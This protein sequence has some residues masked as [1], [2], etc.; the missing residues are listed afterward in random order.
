[1][2]FQ[3]SLVPP[4]EVPRCFEDLAVNEAAKHS[5][6]SSSGSATT[7]PPTANGVLNA[8]CDLSLLLYQIMQYNATQEDVGSDEDLAKRRQYYSEVQSL[9]H[10]IPE[11]LKEENNLTPQTCFLR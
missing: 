9:W 11:Q 7:E 8:T 1:M 10:N 3:Q 4:P 5:P 2:Y 6:G